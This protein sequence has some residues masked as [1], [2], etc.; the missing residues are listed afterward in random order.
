VEWRSHLLSDKVLDVLLE[1]LGVLAGRHR[2]RRDDVGPRQLYRAAIGSV[3]TPCYVATHLCRVLLAMDSDD[4]GVLDSR[5]RDEDG[6]KLG[7]RDLWG[8]SARVGAMPQAQRTWKPRRE[9]FDS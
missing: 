1:G 6:L 8:A 3:R 9:Y 4:G 2:I 5:V 7:G